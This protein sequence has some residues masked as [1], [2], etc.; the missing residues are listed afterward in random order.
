[1][2]YKHECLA[3]T[4]KKEDHTTKETS[5]GLLL[6]FQSLKTHSSKIGVISV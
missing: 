1:M 4:H 6:L 3:I 2:S 5:I